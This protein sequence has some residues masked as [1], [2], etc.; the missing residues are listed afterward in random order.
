MKSDGGNVT[1][2]YDS[3]TSSPSD[4]FHRTT[5][6]TVTVDRSST[7]PLRCSSVQLDVFR[8]PGEDC[9]DGI[10]GTRVS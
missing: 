9:K 2:D 6:T 7:T 10:N 8:L 5:T 3:E 1:T 4:Y